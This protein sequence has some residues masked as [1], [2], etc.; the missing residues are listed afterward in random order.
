[1]STP[2]DVIVVGSG[3]GGAVVA[4]RLAEAGR[5]V[6]VL[7]RG[8]RWSP[9]TFPR[10][11]DDPWLWD[12]FHP[13]RANGWFDFR[14]FGRMAVAAGAG[15]GGGSLVYANV[16]VQPD[17]ALFESGWP[18]EVTFAGLAPHLDAVGRML[19]VAP[20]PA[21]QW[22]ERT[23][24]MRDAAV[25]TG[26]G[27]RF[28]PLDLAVTFDPAWRDDAPGAHSAGRSVR[29]TNAE[30]VEQGTCIHLG[31]CDIGCPV[32][33]RN[34]LDLNYLARAERLGAEIRPLHLVRSI[35][36]EPDGYRVHAE[37]VDA[38]RLVRA[39]ETA[40]RVVVAAGSLG[41]TELL[42][43]S[44][45]V[46]RTLTRLPRSIGQGWSANGDFLTLGDHRSRPV[47]PTVGPTITSAIDF[48]DGSQDGAAFIIEDGGFPD[49]LAD[50]LSRTR[51]GF[52]LR[53]RRRLLQRILDPVLDLDGASVEHLMPWFSQGRDAADGRLH[54][55][56]RWWLLGPWALDLRWDPRASLPVLD[57]I[58]AMHRR[59][60]TSLGGAPHDVPTWAILRYLVTP[61]PLGG[62]RMGADPTTSVVDHRGQVWGHPGLFVADGAIVPRAIGANPSRTIAALAERIAALMI[63]EE[64]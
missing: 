1:M 43:R 20:V 38:G 13:E 15:V 60:A 54:L 51:R 58:A 31:E 56:R 14:M 3:F 55:R 41:S 49:V 39:T 64:S 8:R 26:A 34:T 18:P 50:W 44:R 48:R 29:F 52:H 9:E 16:S 45:D 28:L 35:A 40:R 61:H 2:F 46:D 59:L 10:A 63:S 30:G 42:L 6:L 7:E 37:R 24:M 25:A 21:S 57:A 23:R 27:D 22:P 62:C 12:P 19:A 11:P 36:R 33:A 4:C 53:R 5:K 17:A 32:K 47:R